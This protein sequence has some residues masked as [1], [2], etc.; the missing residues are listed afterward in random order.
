MYSGEDKMKTTILGGILQFI[1]TDEGKD[2]L[3]FIKNAD[4]ASLRACKD[5]RLSEDDKYESEYYFNVGKLMLVNQNEVNIL[6]ASE[7]EIEEKYRL[8]YNKFVN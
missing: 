7:A 4:S 6:V 8:I 1:K 3:Y 5:L 2:L